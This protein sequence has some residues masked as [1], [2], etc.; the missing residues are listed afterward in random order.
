MNFRKSFLKKSYLVL[1][2]YTLNFIVNF[3]AFAQSNSGDF[4]NS[5]SIIQELKV[6]VRTAID[7]KGAIFVT[8][9]SQKCI[10][11]FDSLWNYIGK[12]YIG[13]EP[14]SIAISGNNSMFVGDYH[15]GK[16]YKR[17]SNGTVSVIYSDTI[18][19]SAMVVS[20]VN[21]L[22]VVDSKSKRVIVMNFAGTVLRTFGS[23][24]FLFPTGIAFDRK[25]NR[26]IVSEHGGFGNGFN[27]HTEIRI[28]GTTGNLISTFG[29]WGNTPGKFYRVQGLTVGRCGN[30]YVTDPYQGNISV[31]NEN[32]TYLTKFGIW[33]DTLG[34]LNVPMDVAF[35][36]QERVYVVSLNNS[37]LEVYNIT[38]L[39]PSST[40]LTGSVSTCEGNTVPVKIS[41][42]GTAPWTFTYT[43]NGANP[44]IVTTTFD[45]PYTLN[46]SLAG[47][48][49]VT[50][51]TDANTAGTCFS[52][53]AYVILNPLPTATIANINPGICQGESTNIPVTFTGNAPWSFTYTI[54]G[55]N[56]T[57]IVDIYTNPYN[58]T[59]SLPG[60]YEIIALSGSN[61]EGT[62]FTGSATVTINPAPESTI[63][64][65]DTYLCAGTSATI[66]VGLTGTAPWSLTYTADSQ[67]PV[68]YTNIATSPF[69]FSVFNSGTYRVVALSDSNC[70]GNAFYGTSVVTEHPLP[71]SNFISGNPTIFPNDSALIAIDLKG[72]APWSLT[73]TIDG[74][75]TTTVSNIDSSPYTF[76][77]Q[78]PGV[79]EVIS[80]SDAFCN[81]TILTGSSIVSIGTLTKTLNLTFFLQGLYNGGG[82]MIKTQDETGNHFDMPL[83]PANTA[84]LVTV[85]LHEGSN[86]AF[87][88]Y[89]VSNVVLSTT[90][91]VSLSVPSAL[92]GAYYITIKHRNS[93][94]TTTALP[95]TFSGGIVNYSFDNPSKVFGGNLY[96]TSDGQWAIYGGDV[97]QDGVVDAGDMVLLD[98]DNSTF[99]KGYLA[100]DINGDGIVDVGDMTILDHNSASFVSRILP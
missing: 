31:F 46:A 17:L 73:Y 40:I 76:Y 72:T 45:N 4:V 9:A 12:I 38:D 63:L 10:V 97:N 68:T 21:E 57:T 48:Y 49:N 94:E 98:N 36:S 42:T 66:Q 6:P 37:A 30:I 59:A 88:A 23:G 47:A 16:I 11:Q 80:L 52:N 75:N 7:N 77:V 25:N 2:S 43:I 54:N 92:S 13:V 62:V 18:F 41:F 53:T 74:A 58:L 24:V 14:T 99:A 65:G 50:A 91:S 33:G 84:D 44:H 83:Y 29:G 8:D 1:I 71:E 89:T 69:S 20:P 87:V 35:D 15:N 70:N 39:L 55:L 81:G 90:G 79:Y 19:P 28:F 82:T 26:V 5:A 61:C 27:L 3:N 64:T 22:Y 100:T 95:A 86:Y 85:E 32:G 93:I 34:N 78:Q 56:P 67:N 60:T 96:Q 51:L